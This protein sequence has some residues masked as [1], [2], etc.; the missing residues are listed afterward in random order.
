[1]LRFLAASL[2]VSVAVPAL[3]RAE[4]GRPP[5]L[6]ALPAAAPLPFYY[7]LYSFRGDTGAT[8]VVASFAVQAGRLDRESVEGGVRY[9]FNVTFVVADTA[10]GIV[11][12]A[13]DSVSVAVPRPLGGEH[14]LHAHLETQ[15]APSTTTVGR[16]V[17]H[18]VPNPGTGQLYN[19]DFS[20]PDY[21]GSE[22]MLSDIALGLPD[23]EGG[24]RRGEV[25]LA[26]LPSSHFPGGPF[27][28]YYEVYNLPQGTRYAT[29]IAVEPVDGSGA[30]RA[31]A[32]STVRVR[33]AGESAADEAD[34][35]GELRRVD[36]PLELGPHRLTVTVTDLER[37]LS[38]SRSRILQVREWEEGATLVLTC[39]VKPGI[40]RPG[41]PARA[42]T[43]GSRR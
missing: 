14:L 6:E 7:D 42:V 43:E 38:A 32:E 29:E 26:L 19:H 24:W 17:M 33:F 23:R 35:L 22:L 41:C 40:D 2:V 20:I 21:G 15:A 25:T 27:D 8:A 3:W 13:D 30:P 5:E 1:M 37:G 34:V 11:A 36:V 16:I 31:G 28:V 10:D 18:A 12:R 4:R 39:P 9:R